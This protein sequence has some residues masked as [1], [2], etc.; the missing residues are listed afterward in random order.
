MITL[1]ARAIRWFDRHSRRVKTRFKLWKYRSIGQTDIARGAILEP[2]AVIDLAYNPDRD[3]ILTIGAGTIV[4]DGAYLAPRSGFIHIGQGCSINRNCI[5]L[6][7]GGITLGNHVRVAA[8][9]SVIAFNHE[10]ELLEVSILEQ[11][12]R[13]QGVIIEDDVWLGNGVKVLDGVTIG[14]GSVIGAGSV[15]TKSIPS[16]SVAVGVPARVLRKRGDRLRPATGSAA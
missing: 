16:N 5:F 6:G 1:V 14:R 3:V 4:K 12:N 13:W 9:T 15:V 2:E 11:G 10:F 7:Y 8:N